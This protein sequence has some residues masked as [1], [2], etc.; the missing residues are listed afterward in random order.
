MTHIINNKKELQNLLLAKV[1]PGETLGFVPTMGA[2]HEGHLAII[3]K[4]KQENSAVVVSIYVN[5]RQFNNR[6]DY[7]SYPRKN[8]EDIALLSAM[9]VDAVYFPIKEELFNPNFSLPFVDLKGLDQRLEGASRPGHFQGVMEVV[10]AL[11]QHVKPDKAYFGL[12]DF[13]QVAVIRKLIESTNLPIEL[14]EQATVRTAEGL[15]MSSRNLRLNPQQKEEALVL[16]H[17]L[18]FLKDNY[19]KLPLLNLLESGRERITKSTLTLD[20]LEIVD[21]DNLIALS[22]EQPKALACVAAFCG[23]VRLIDNMLLQ[24]L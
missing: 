8:E 6:E 2:L 14:V 12:K 20:Y 22:S 11:F 15:A 17:T 13:Q 16:V 3:R 10:Y 19:G 23:E 18:T 21:Y 5:D 4:A 24:T 1:S 7:I 9:D